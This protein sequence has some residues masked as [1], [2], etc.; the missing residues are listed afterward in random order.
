M[1]DDDVVPSMLIDGGC[2]GGGVV[3]ARVAWVISRFTDSSRREFYFRFSQVPGRSTNCN[4][5]DGAVRISIQARLSIPNVYVDT[6]LSARRNLWI[7]LSL[8]HAAG[9]CQ[10]RQPTNLKKGY[11]DPHDCEFAISWLFQ[12]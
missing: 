8:A 6:R 7:Y 4:G 9:D 12:A 3:E 1:S 10:P 5:R 11:C 2:G